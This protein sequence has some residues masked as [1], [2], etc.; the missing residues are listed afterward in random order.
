MTVRFDRR[1]LLRS[2][3]ALAAA[4]PIARAAERKRVAVLATVVH[5]Y[6]HAQHFIDR[7]LEG[8]GWAGAHHRP[9]LDL[10][11]LYVEQTPDG[12][13]SRDRARRFPTLKIYPTIAE[14]LTLGG[15]KL[16][17]DGV[18]II[19]EHG[20]YPKNGKGQKMYPRRR[21]FDET[22]KVFEASGRV[23]PVFNDK[24]LSWKWEDALAMVQTAQRLGL[25]LMAG[26]S[27]PV[28]R[29]IP[30]VDLSSGAPLVESV[31]VA[32]GGVD[33]YDIHA[34]ELAQSMSERRRGGETGI[35]SIHAVRGRRVWGMLRDRPRTLRLV[36][37]AMCRSHE[38][39]PPDGWT[40]AEP[41][42][43][44]AAEK[45][46]EPVAYFCEHEGGFRTTMVLM[47][48]LIGDFNYAGALEDGSTVSFQAYLPMP[49]ART[50]LADFFSPQL[51]H[52]ERMVATGRPP[53]PIERTLL[54][55]GMTAF[56]V[57]SL[58][59]GDIPVE[60]PELAIAYA[61]SAESTFWNV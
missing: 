31:T 37:A 21:F 32:Y 11:S 52:F 56:A 5:K 18:L 27:L 60:T 41:T 15:S 19:G 25:P 35:S 50:T 47:N 30:A 38:L 46:P 1:S 49:P 33:A 39:A 61:A 17:V 48:K 53:L 9:S 6:A 58:Y 24:H 34:L 14:A 45:C 51:N 23:V 40:L 16:A 55:T 42:L 20:E 43:A 4:V 8:Y 7:L 44:W 26:S 10:V 22:V 28:T 13:L 2:S 54:T 29:R 59:R 36:E 3:A 57:E 12:D